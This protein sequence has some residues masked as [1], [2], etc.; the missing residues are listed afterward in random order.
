V[1]GGRAREKIMNGGVEYWRVNR[2]GYNLYESRI[3]GISLGGGCGIVY[4]VQRVEF[5]WIW[6]RSLIVLD[7]ISLALSWD[8]IA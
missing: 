6:V 1:R 8:I 3:V 7:L 4:D 5:F 2:G